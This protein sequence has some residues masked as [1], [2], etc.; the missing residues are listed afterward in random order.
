MKTIYCLLII[1]LWCSCNETSEIGAGFFKEGNL[2]LNYTDTLTLKV[3]TVTADSIVTGAATRLLV[4][5]H[6]DDDLG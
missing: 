3:S 6:V 1:I 2:G 5:N 4:G